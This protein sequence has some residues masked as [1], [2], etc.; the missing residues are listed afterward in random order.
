MIS[1]SSLSKG[2]GFSIE[3]T[4]SRANRIIAI[5]ASDNPLYRWVFT[6]PTEY[7]VVSDTGGRAH[8]EPAHISYGT[9]WTL[10]ARQQDDTVYTDLTDDEWQIIEQWRKTWCQGAPSLRP[11]QNDEASYIVALRC[12]GY[13]ATTFHVPSDQMPAAIATILRRSTHSPVP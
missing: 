11:V 4:I 8:H 1:L 5:D 7:T 9:A 13:N 3:S 12:S 6:T 10:S 2:Q